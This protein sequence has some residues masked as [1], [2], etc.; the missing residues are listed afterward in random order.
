MTSQFETS[1]VI[2]FNSPEGPCHRTMASFMLLLS[3]T[4]R[5]SAEIA[6]TIATSFAEVERLVFLTVNMGTSMRRLSWSENL[7][8]S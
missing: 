2:T 4:E 5:Q 3:V 1:P 8:T 6:A 7:D